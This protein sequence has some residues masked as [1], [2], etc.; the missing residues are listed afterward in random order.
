MNTHT[1]L[2]VSL[3]G[4]DGTVLKKF[5]KHS[6]LVGGLFLVLGLLGIVVPSALSLVAS[7]FLGWML[8]TG[9][10]LSL[11]FAFLTKWRS[12]WSWVKALLLAVT[13]GLILLH[14]VAGILAVAL[15]IALYLVMDGVGNF[16]LAQALYP[17]KGWGWMAANGVLSLGLALVMVFALPATTVVLVGLYLG[18]SLLF[19][20][21]AL[22][23][24]GMAAKNFGG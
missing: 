3:V 1:S 22:V 21:I 7:S 19:D 17:H 18:I 5:R 20:G 9:G 8:L 23:M 6:L 12:A 2:T 10:I 13:G 24:L 16:T 11:Y 15:L 4:F 14:P